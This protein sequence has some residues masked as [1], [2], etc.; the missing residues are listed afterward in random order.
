MKLRLTLDVD[1]EPH[2][3]SAADLVDQLERAVLN[4]V[5][6][7]LLSG[8]GPAEVDSWTQRIEVVSYTAT[9]V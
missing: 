5:D 7:G 9:S 2:G 1:Y 3:E 6:N 4:C 8:D